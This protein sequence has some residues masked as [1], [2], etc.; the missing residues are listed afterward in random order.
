MKRLVA[1]RN[2]TPV[3][4][5][6]E[7]PQLCHWATTIRQPPAFKILYMYT[8]SEV[9]M[10]HTSYNSLSWV[11]ATEAVTNTCAVHSYRGLWG[12]VVVWLSYVDRWQSTGS[13]RQCPGFV[14]MEAGD[15]STFFYCYHISL[16]LWKAVTNFQNPILCPLIRYCNYVECGL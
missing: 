3:F 15:F 9:L 4:E 8:G 16:Y 1:N 11:A 14:S 13:P 5:L 6:A 2:Q 10:A 7:L 12:L